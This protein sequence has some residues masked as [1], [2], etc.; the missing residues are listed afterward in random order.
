MRIQ[1]RKVMKAVDKNWVVYQGES[2]E[3]FSFSAKSG[4]PINLLYVVFGE[5]ENCKLIKSN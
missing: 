3:S 1:Q 5:L 4:V 2:P